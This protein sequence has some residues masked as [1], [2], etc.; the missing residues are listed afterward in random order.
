[1]PTPSVTMPTTHA[2]RR[3]SAIIERLC[4]GDSTIDRVRRRL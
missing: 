4:S 3:G 2:K 1:M